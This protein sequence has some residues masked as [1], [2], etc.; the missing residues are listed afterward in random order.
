MAE[1]IKENQGLDPKEGIKSPSH[2]GARMGDEGQDYKRS[3]VLE[4]RESGR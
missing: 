2:N 4:K 3:E 1:S